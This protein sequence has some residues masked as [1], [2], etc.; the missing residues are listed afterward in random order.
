[1]YGPSPMPHREI[2]IKLELAPADLPGLLDTPPLRT[3]KLVPRRTREISVYFDTGKRKL[4]SKNLLLRVRRVGNRY[5][6][7]IK[8]GKNEAP[9]ERDE[10]EGEIAGGKPDLDLARG[11]ALEALV[12]RKLRRRLQPVFETRVQ[13]TVYPVRD[14]T[15]AI[16]LAVD[17]G[18]IETGSRSLPLCE[19]ELEL[20]QGEIT[21]LF[22]FARELVA[23]LPARLA[24]KSKSERGYELLENESGAAVKAAAV[25]PLIT[26]NARETFKLIGLACLKQVVGNEPAVIAGHPEGVHQM[27]VGLR[28]LRAG[29]AVFSALLRDRQTAEIKRD[30]K[31]LA[32]ELGPARELE[33]LLSRVVG[34][35]QDQQHRWKGMPSLS[36]EF[37]ER[38][39][40]ALRRAR[41]AVQSPRF[42]TLMLDVAAW[43]E[44]G[45][46]TAPQDDLVRDQGAVPVV[47]FA[48]D[49][50]SRRWRKLRKKGKALAELDPASRHKLR[51]HAK[52]LRYA[53]EFF[54][55]LFASKRAGEKRRKRFLAALEALQDSLGDLND[56]A[57]HE[58]RI[59]AMGIDRQKPNPN[60]AFAAGLLT[61]RENARIEVAMKSATEAYAVLAKRKPFWK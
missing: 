60:R 50:L 52:K 45:H 15:C 2:E 6:Q 8:A 14:D 47:D 55:G 42:R 46:W 33:V 17:R 20:E 57:V 10:W 19:V 44:A 4:H 3:Q 54:A 12:T 35:L 36:R 48:G 16:M 39:D 27:R 61:G 29:M 51:I 11:T 26:A 13:R 34:P 56:I 31:W 53:A 9:L 30:L 5:I 22:A 7:T 40:A 1:M 38:R 28:R 58:R 18:S 43:L 41:E 59:P 49:W 24:L 21:G 25:D 32:R 37:A 23:A